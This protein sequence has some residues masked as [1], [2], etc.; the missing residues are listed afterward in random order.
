MDE[1]KIAPGFT[2]SAL[3]ETVSYEQI[4][5]AVEEH[6]AAAVPGDK[7]WYI[8]MDDNQYTVCEGNVVPE[9]EPDPEPSDTP[10]DTPAPT[11]EDDLAALVV[12]HEYRLSLLEFEMADKTT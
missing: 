9:P 3:E 5:A 4:E 8:S 2:A 11:E 12:D 1:I 7:Y 6:N 10:T